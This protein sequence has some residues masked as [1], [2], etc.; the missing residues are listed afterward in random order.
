MTKGAVLEQAAPP[1][2][3]LATNACAYIAADAVGQAHL[4]YPANAYVL[5]V[6]SPVLFPDSF[7]YECFEKGFA[8][9]II[10]S[11]GHECPYPGAFERLAKRIDRVKLELKERGIDPKLLRLTAICTVCTKAYL[12]EIADMQ[13]RVL[14]AASASPVASTG[15]GE[16]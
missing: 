15:G 11:C 10:M 8:G 12:K 5:R 14:A 7:Y 3:V 2:L 6:L 16:A 1:I 4:H 13:E 9:I